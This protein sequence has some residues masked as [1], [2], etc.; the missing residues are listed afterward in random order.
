MRQTAHTKNRVETRTLLAATLAC[1]LAG[2]ACVFALSYSLAALATP[3][4]KRQ[5]TAVIAP[6][7]L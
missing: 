5:T 2:L 6:Y 4:L 3:G 7:G 1:Y